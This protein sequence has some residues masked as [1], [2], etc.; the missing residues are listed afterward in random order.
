MFEK[1]KRKS[2]TRAFIISPVKRYNKGDIRML[3]LNTGMT[4]TVFANFMGV[5]KKTVEAWEC[6]R[7]R[8]GGSACR[9]MQLLSEYGKETMHF[10]RPVS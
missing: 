2:G 7:I 9:L 6:G 1:E 4:Q 5:S 8:P 3:R 10:F